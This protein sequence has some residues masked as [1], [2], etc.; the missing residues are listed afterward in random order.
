MEKHHL[1]LQPLQ[2]SKPVNLGQMHYSSDVFQQIWN[3]ERIPVTNRA[4]LKITLNKMHTKT[5]D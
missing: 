3:T 1:G 5:C 4:T 2:C